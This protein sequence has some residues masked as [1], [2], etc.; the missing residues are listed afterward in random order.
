M[1]TGACEEEEMDA[2]ISEIE[3]VMEEESGSGGASFGMLRM[4]EEVH[5]RAG[6][7]IV[8][9]L[10]AAKFRRIVTYKGDFLVA[11]EH[12][13]VIITLLDP[14]KRVRRKQKARETKKKRNTDFKDKKDKRAQ[15]RA[16]RMAEEEAEKERLR[17]EGFFNAVDAE[18][19]SDPPPPDSDEDD[20][21]PPGSDDE[22]DPPP[23]DSDDESDPPPPGSDD[24]S[25]PPPPDSDAG[26]DP[27]PPGSDDES[28][29]LP[30]GSDDDDAPP[31]VS[32]EGSDAPK[33]K[34]EGSVSP[35]KAK[36]SKP[37]EETPEE[38]KKRLEEMAEWEKTLQKRRNVPT[39]D[40]V[41]YKYDELRVSTTKLT[42]DDINVMKRET[43]L[44]DEDF[45][46]VFGMS[47]DEF[48]KLPTWRKAK[49]KNEKDLF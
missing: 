49:M 28:E 10:N 17:K 37:V 38:K 25:D 19:E 5:R 2:L 27:P 18:E 4:D 12:D 33:E 31:P 47:P 23:P 13:D 16:E 26:S 8:A 41:K 9:S 3:R 40:D 1:A 21:P 15:E 45:Q 29:P 36:K 32:D 39:G 20:P 34:T 11:G 46:E 7:R 30:P 24:E 42:R 35:K 44:S 14:A 22:S 43:Y 6:G 48:N